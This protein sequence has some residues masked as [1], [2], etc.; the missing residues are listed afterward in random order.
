MPMSD[1]FAITANGATASL[2]AHKAKKISTFRRKKEIQYAAIAAIGIF[3]VLSLGLFIAL[4]VEYPALNFSRASSKSA[5]AEPA[6]HPSNGKITFDPIGGHR[7]RQ[8]TFDNKTGRVTET[9]KPCE[10]LALDDKGLT[11][12][13]GTI[14]RLDAISKSFSSNEAF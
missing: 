13:V 1:K 10:D 8:M 7:C 4:M 6:F 5:L 3:I 9:N 12:P 11:K 14:H 2:P